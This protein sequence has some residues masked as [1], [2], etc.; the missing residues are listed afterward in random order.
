MTKV[1]PLRIPGVRSTVVP[2]ILI[3]GPLIR[4]YKF[5]KFTGKIGP[6]RVKFVRKRVGYIGFDPGSP[7]SAEPL[8][9]YTAK[10]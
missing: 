6:F 2:V 7:L 5:F 8:T 1:A 10:C 4:K 9:L 3:S